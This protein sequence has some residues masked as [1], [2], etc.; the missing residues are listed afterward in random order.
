[1]CCLLQE[2]VTSYSSTGSISLWSLGIPYSM[3]RK[4]RTEQALEPPVPTVLPW[5][6][7]SWLHSSRSLWCSDRASGLALPW[8]PQPVLA[9]LSSCSTGTS[10]GHGTDL[11][12]LEAARVLCPQRWLHFY[13]P[14]AC[15]EPS[16]GTAL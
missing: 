6:E 3:V 13:S 9:R 14:A 10:R 1:M 4:Q 15:D 7:G 11:T 8:V 12:L 16:E 5:L 2:L